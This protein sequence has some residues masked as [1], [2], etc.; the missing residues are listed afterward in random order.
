MEDYCD[1]NNAMLVFNDRSQIGSSLKNGYIELMTHRRCLFEDKRGVGN[2]LNETENGQGLK[3]QLHHYL[4]F[5]NRELAK[6]LQ[7]RLDLQPLIVLSNIQ[8]KNNKDDF[9][10]N[11]LF[12]FHKLILNYEFKIKTFLSL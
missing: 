10:N 11:G 9:T 12:K 5:G 8:K 2:A 7:Y 1:I 6:K 4:E 3:F